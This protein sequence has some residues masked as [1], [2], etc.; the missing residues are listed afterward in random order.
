MTPN[1]SDQLL[2]AVLEFGRLMHRKCAENKE[3][4]WLQIRALGLI[5]EK[6]GM[7]MTEFAEALDVTSPSATSFAQKLVDLGWI[8][9][10]ADASNRK[11]V[12]LQLTAQGRTALA[13]KMQAHRDMIRS[14]HSSIPL[15]DQA[16][17]LRILQ[18]MITTTRSSQ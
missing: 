2:D 14:V 12:R 3:G 10:R 9:R 1:V 7:T 17:L 16:Q 8:E 6:Q 5:A 18:T 11:L 15:E 13:E 4:N